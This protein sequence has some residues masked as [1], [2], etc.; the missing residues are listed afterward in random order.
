MPFPRMRVDKPLALIHKRLDSFTVTKR[1]FDNYAR[2]TGNSGPAAEFQSRAVCI[3]SARVVNRE[4]HRLPTKHNVQLSNARECS[5]R[6][7]LW[8]LSSAASRV[9]DLQLH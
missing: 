4:N 3:I 5:A 7:S 8:L 9:R 1:N 6:A 2:R